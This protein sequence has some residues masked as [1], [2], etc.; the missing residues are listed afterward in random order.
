M[1][2]GAFCIEHSS[3]TDYEKR[4]RNIIYP[5]RTLLTKINDAATVPFALLLI[6]LG[7]PYILYMIFGGIQWDRVFTKK[8]L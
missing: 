2:I 8:D 3:M 7:W 4:V 1:A 5:N 6:L